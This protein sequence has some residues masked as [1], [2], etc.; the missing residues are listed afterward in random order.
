MKMTIT[1]TGET[2]VESIREA[3]RKGTL[4]K[5]SIL[6]FGD[7]AWKVLDVDVVEDKAL[8]FRVKGSTVYMAFNEN[9]SNEYEGSDIQKYLR[10]EFVATLPE[11]LKEL[12]KGNG[13]AFLLSLEEAK[14]YMPR[15]IDRIVYDEQGETEWWWTRSAYRGYAYNTWYVYS[16]GYVHSHTASYAT[17]FA[18]ACG[19]WIS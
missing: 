10:S 4:E 18:P 15:E 3:I 16:S 5:G 2:T 17:R 12:A 8:I 6:E 9:G 7:Q 11:E 1:L 13:D 19:L 14:K